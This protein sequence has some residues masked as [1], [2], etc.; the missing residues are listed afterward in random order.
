MDI[1]R[2]MEVTLMLMDLQATLGHPFVHVKNGMNTIGIQATLNVLNVIRNHLFNDGKLLISNAVSFFCTS[3]ILLK[4]KGKF[5]KGSMTS[6][7]KKNRKPHK[8]KSLQNAMTTSH[9]YG[10]IT[11]KCDQNT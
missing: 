8:K 11:F 1:H 6:P 9:E 4:I 3:F 10:I 2:R 7:H 5:L